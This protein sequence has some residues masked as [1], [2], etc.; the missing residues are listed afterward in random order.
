MKEGFGLGILKQGLIPTTA[1]EK[2]QKILMHT[3]A[4]MDCAI[5]TDRWLAEFTPNENAVIVV[6]DNDYIKKC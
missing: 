2:F 6:E 3:S 4:A 5:L 1:E